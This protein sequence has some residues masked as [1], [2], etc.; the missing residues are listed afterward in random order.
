MILR[1]WANRIAVESL[2]QARAQDPAEDPQ[3]PVDQ[4][5]LEDPHPSTRTNSTNCEHR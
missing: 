5:D 4:A 2:R 3:V 1:Q